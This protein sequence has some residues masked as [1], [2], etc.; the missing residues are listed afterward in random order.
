[1]EPLITVISPVYNGGKY[2]QQFID[3]IRN[4]TYTNWELLL[5]DD[6]ST[7]NSPSIIANNAKADCRKKHQ[8][9]IFHC[10]RL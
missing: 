2:I 5:V 4:Q 1:M 8:R 6:G 7:D 9:K 10:F 3:S